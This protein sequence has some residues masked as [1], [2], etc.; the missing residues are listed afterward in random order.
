[1]KLNIPSNPAVTTDYLQ[2]NLAVFTT[3]DISNIYDKSDSCT[4]APIEP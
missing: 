4:L 1:L 3:D 2:N